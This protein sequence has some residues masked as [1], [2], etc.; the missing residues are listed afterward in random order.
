MQLSASRAKWPQGQKDRTRL[1]Y[2]NRQIGGC[3]L[4]GS[5]IDYERLATFEFGRRTGNKR[6]GRRIKE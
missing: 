1:L 2:F 6:M 3:M 4:V 5:F